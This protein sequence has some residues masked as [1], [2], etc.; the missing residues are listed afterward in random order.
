V[1]KSLINI[2]VI[3][4]VFLAGIILGK[5]YFSKTEIKIVD[6][7]QYKTEWKTKIIK[8]NTPAN[9]DQ[10]YNCYISPIT[11]NADVKENIFHVTAKDDCKE[12]SADFKVK[13]S[14]KNGWKFYAGIAA[15]GILAGGIVTYKLLK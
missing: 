2:I 3:V 4:A 15:A 8:E 6:R 13:V 9:F 1:K 10:L 11:I 12:S 5:L 14:D 7:V